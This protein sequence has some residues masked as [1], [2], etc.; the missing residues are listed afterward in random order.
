MFCFP[1]T[2]WTTMR[3]ASTVA[4]I[5]QSE[6]QWLDLQRFQDIVAW[7]E[8][9][10]ITAGRSNEQSMTTYQTAPTKDESLFQPVIAAI[11]YEGVLLKVSP[12]LMLSAS[13][14][15]ARWLRWVLSATG[16]PTSSWDA[17]FRL[18][19]AANLGL[20]LQAGLRSPPLRPNGK[21]C[22]GDCQKGGS[23]PIAGAAPKPSTG[24]N[25][26]QRYS[27]VGRNAWS[28]SARQRDGSRPT[29]NDWHPADSS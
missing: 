1:L 7:L 27:R 6:A 11:N 22:N 13:V 17:T 26:A 16:A 5:T 28:R 20:N 3:G 19:I 18:W 14:P 24:T 29:T 8:V 4:A 2:T 10:N 15:N 9:K 21:S 23:T 12:G 25:P